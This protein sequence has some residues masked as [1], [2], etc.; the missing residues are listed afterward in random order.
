MPL[1][2]A[3]IVVTQTVEIP[4]YAQ[5]EEDAKR[6]MAGTEEWKEDGGLDEFEK[7]A[8]SFSGSVEKV[9]DPKQTDFDGD[10]ICWDEKSEEIHVAVAFFGM[11]KWPE[12]PEEE[13]EQTMTEYEAAADKYFEEEKKLIEQFDAAK[14]T[15]NDQGKRTG[16]S[17]SF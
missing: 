6:Y 8:M 9:T 17:A 3:K 2:K 1:Y 5:S 10:C 4:V 12:Y 16:K 13:T 7:D 15:P 14:K 11:P